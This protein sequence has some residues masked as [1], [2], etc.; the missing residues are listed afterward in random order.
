MRLYLDD[1]RP[2]PSGFDLR[3]YTAHEAIDLLKQGNITFIS[4]DHDLGEAEN[5][6]GYDVAKWIEEAVIT[7]NFLLPDWAVHSANPVGRQNI[8]SAMLSAEKYFYKRF[9]LV[10]LFENDK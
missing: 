3:V 8:N 10:F 4:F 7:N 9:G 6:T 2:T 5:G 1:I